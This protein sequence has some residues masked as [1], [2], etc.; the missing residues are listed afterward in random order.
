FFIASHQPGHHSY[1]DNYYHRVAPGPVWLRHVESDAV[2]ADHEGEGREYGGDYS[3][4]LHQLVLLN[5][6]WER[7]VQKGWLTIFSGLSTLFR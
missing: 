1:A 4:D 7:Y 2:S 6:G 5:G 3:K